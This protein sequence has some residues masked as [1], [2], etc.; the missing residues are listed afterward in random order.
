MLTRIRAIGEN[1][2]KELNSELQNLSAALKKALPNLKGL[3]EQYE[4]VFNKIREELENDKN[5]K[6]LAAIM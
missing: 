5:F 1:L 2:G 4:K 6:Q 3:N